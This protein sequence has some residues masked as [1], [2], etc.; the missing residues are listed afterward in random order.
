MDRVF[1]E[2]ER[3]FPSSFLQTSRRLLTEAATAQDFADFD[4]DEL[5]QLLK[6]SSRGRFGSEKAQAF[7]VTAQ[8]SI[9]LFFLADAARTLP[10]LF[11][12]K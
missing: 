3:L 2:Y 9:D 8:R 5:T 11:W 6:Q 12:A 4:L 10:P 1:P 7:Q